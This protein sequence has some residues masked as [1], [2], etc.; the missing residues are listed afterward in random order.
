[1]NKWKEVKCHYQKEQVVPDTR[2]KNVAHIFKGSG[3][4]EHSV[5]SQKN[6]I[7]GHFNI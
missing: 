1:M 5:I 3:S 6:G 2:N 7:Q 4:K